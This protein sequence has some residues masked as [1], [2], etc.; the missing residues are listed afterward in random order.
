MSAAETI[1]WRFKVDSSLSPFA[2]LG[3]RYLPMGIGAV[4]VLQFLYSFARPLRYVFETEAI[5]LRVW[6]WLFLGSLIFFLVVVSA[7]RVRVSQ[8]P[9]PP[10]RRSSALSRMESHSIVCH[11][12]ASGI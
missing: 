6:P 5:P 3:N 9:R 1:A 7:P 10:R 4:V 11:S 12:R 2:H 8:R